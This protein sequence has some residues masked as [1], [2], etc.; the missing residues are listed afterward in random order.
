[1]QLRAL[2]HEANQ[3]KGRALRTG[4]AVATGDVVVV[5]DADLEY[6]PGD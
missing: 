6:D 5:Q 3:G 2:Y 4:F 1:V